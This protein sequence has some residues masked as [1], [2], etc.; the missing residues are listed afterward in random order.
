MQYR[1]LGVYHQDCGNDCE[2]AS[3]GWIP[4]DILRAIQMKYPELNNGKMELLKKV[5]KE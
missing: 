5:I 4:Y 3:Q 1:G 2:I